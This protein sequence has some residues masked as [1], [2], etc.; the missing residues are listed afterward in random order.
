MNMRN[1]RLGAVAVLA[2]LLLASWSFAVSAQEAR[3]ERLVGVRLP[4]SGLFKM[5]K[6]GDLRNEL[7]IV[8]DEVSVLNRTVQSIKFDPNAP[9]DEIEK[10]FEGAISLERH[11]AELNSM[12]DRF[13]LCMAAMQSK[14]ADRRAEGKLTPDE[15]TA[16]VACE[17]HCLKT[18]DRINS[19]YHNTSVMVTANRK[20]YF[21][22]AWQEHQKMM[23]ELEKLAAGCPMMMEE[24]LKVTGEPA[25]ETQ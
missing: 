1:D 5:V 7:K 25:V 21:M 17:A 9:K 8:T 14:A 11:R 13:S 16:L 2:G 15:E 24:A 3:E 19:L 23:A 10:Q 12:R 18:L 6:I 20:T 4:G 22:Q